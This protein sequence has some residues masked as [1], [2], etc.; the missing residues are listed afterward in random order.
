MNAQ[1]YFIMMA[2]GWAGA[3]L[4]YALLLR[5][6]GIKPA[7]AVLTAVLALPLIFIG[8]KGLFLLPKP[9]VIGN[10][11]LKALW[12]MNPETFSFV[13][14][15]AG[16]AAACLTAAALLKADRKAALDR[17]A[18]PFCLGIAAARGAEAFLDALGTGDFVEAPRM[19]FFP[20]AVRD[21]WG[22][23]VLAVFMLECFW[24]FLSAAL[25]IIRRKKDARFPGLSFEIALFCLCSGQFILELWR[26]CSVT[27]LVEVHT[28]QILCL[29]VM[30]VLM[31]RS[32]ILARRTTEPR[33]SL[34]RDLIPIWTLIPFVALNMYLQFVLDK[35]WKYI[36]PFLPE[37]VYAWVDSHLALMVYG[38]MIL[39]VAGLALLFQRTVIRRKAFGKAAG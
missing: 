34:L 17:F 9:Y 19:Q 37:N 13:G 12:D 32:C 38:L 24:A 18:V 1:A 35:P 2:A 33:R 31:L 6:G 10:A 25:V 20:L 3:G 23:W 11:G 36:E 15:C 28:E 22:D 29:V 21:S 7:L 8:A 14:G 5:R 4:L 16:A 39:S 30:A 27:I 26:T